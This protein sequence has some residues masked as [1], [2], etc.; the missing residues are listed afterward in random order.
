MKFS[1]LLCVVSTLL[2][3]C[4][5]VASLAAASDTS[6]EEMVVVAKKQVGY[7]DGSATS[8]MRQDLSLLE[9]PA[10]VF[11]A[12]SELIADQQSFRLD[13]ILQNDASVQ[14]ANN[15][16]GA[17][18]SYQVR[19]F[20]LLNGSNYLRDGRAFFQLASA[21][22][23]VLD[24][25]E[26]LKGPASVLY[27]TLAP[28]G[29]VNMVPKKPTEEFQGMVK[30]TAGSFDLQHLHVDVGGSIDPGG[31]VQYRV[32]VVNEESEY[33]REFFDGSA[34]DVDRDIYA[35]ALSWDIS[36]RTRLSMN[37]DQ[38][39][40]DR[41]QDNGLIGAEGEVFDILDYDLIYNQPW[42]HYDSEVSNVVVELDHQ[43]TDAWR[44]KT[45]YS[46]QEFMRDRYDNQLRSFDP[47]TG[48][49]VIRARRRLN[50]RDYE[51]YYL[52]VFGEFDTG[53]LSHNLL[54]GVDTTEIDRRDREI[55]NADRVTFTSNIFGEA[56][57]DPRIPIGNRRVEGDETRRGFY[58][59]DMI[60]LTDQWRVLVGARYDD[61][62]TT[63]GNSYEIDNLTP[64]AGVVYL[65]QDNL[66]V[67]ASYSESFEPNG[68]VG[69][70]FANEGEQLDPTVGSMWEA[71]V[72]W[73]GYDGN[74]LIAS[75]VFTI[76]REGSPIEDPVANTIEQRGLQRHR[77][78]ELTVSGLVGERLSLIGSA[79]FLDAEIIK[80]DDA[81][82]VGNSPF[83]VA[84]RSLSLWAEYQFDGWIPG[85]SLQ[86]GVFYESD[87]PVDD[88]NSFDL[89]AYTRIDIGAKY[90]YSMRNESD[91]TA[92]LTVSNVTDEEYFKARTPFAIN[93]ERPR[94]V[95]FS[96]QYSF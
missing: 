10:S 93:P 30:A 24:R 87:R 14:K 43:F 46:L 8:A 48:D 71:G 94:E 74:L 2:G 50:R 65:P 31:R 88:A 9:T 38:T 23:E 13:Q 81:S 55:E 45:G 21:P 83:G 52:D 29:L 44:L 54:V 32:N 68:P 95:R 27:G 17:Y 80:D 77:G 72:K 70:G 82:L 42:S 40:D 67:Y 26:V 22:T 18:S 36:S 75:A 37:Y 28:G 6:I 15:F 56:F 57:P 64:R 61:Y 41:P 59:Q 47:E 76:E 90:V 7:H 3:L 58:F 4:L 16:L 86:G 78:A 96:L 35:I 89:D 63:I 79:A 33:F 25:V 39:D 53:A 1:K 51:T 73:E 85:F 20:N 5:P 12:N 66:S 19:G 34:F 49:N 69:G 91:L 11:I 92:R 84:E 60:S 62:E